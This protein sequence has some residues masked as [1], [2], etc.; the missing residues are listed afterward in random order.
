M[1][2]RTLYACKKSVKKGQSHKMLM[3][4]YRCIEVSSTFQMLSVNSYFCPRTVSD[5]NRIRKYLH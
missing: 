1:E 3:D 5:Q 2:N 4:N